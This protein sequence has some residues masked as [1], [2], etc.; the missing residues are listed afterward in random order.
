MTALLR[1]AALVC[2]VLGILSALAVLARSRDVQLSVGVLLEFLLAAGLLR[3]SAD[4]TV[5]ALVTAVVIIGLRRLIRFGLGVRTGM[6][7]GTG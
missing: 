4:P 3:L 5:Q 7:K 6:T 2:T 1:E